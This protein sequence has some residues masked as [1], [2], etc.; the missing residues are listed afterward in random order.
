MFGQSVSRQSAG[1]IKLFILCCYT[2][3][4]FDF[5]VFIKRIRL[6]RRR[7]YPVS[8]CK[9]T[10]YEIFATGFN[11]V[12]S[13][14]HFSAA[15]RV[16]FVKRP[17]IVNNYYR[18]IT[19]MRRSIVYFPTV[20]IYLFIFFSSL[21]ELFFEFVFK[22]ADKITIFLLFIALRPKIKIIKIFINA[23]RNFYHY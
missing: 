16:A 9:R 12:W 14:L 1:S 7:D 22:E 19:L 4:V 15:D 18:S 21:Y 20:C 17:M 3:R 13:S 23:F 11:V 8:I 6:K 5:R 10:K 2:E